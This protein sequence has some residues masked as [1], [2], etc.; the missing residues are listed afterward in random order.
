MMSGIARNLPLILA[1]AVVASTISGVESQ[2]CAR[3]GRKAIACGARNGFAEC[4]PGAK[5]SDDEDEKLCVVDK[6][7]D[8]TADGQEDDLPEVEIAVFPPTP[9]R[10]PVAVPAMK[11]TTE[12]TAATP[13][14]NEPFSSFN[15]I[16]LLRPATG[17]IKESGG[18]H[19]AI[20]G[21]SKRNW[22]MLLAPSAVEVPV[23]SFRLKSSPILLERDPMKFTEMPSS[24]PSSSPS[25]APTISHA[26]SDLPSSS[27]T[28]YIWISEPLPAESDMDN[29]Y[30]DYNPS[31]P[32]GP[33]RWHKVEEQ[34]LEGEYW[35][36]EYSK[37]IEPDLDKNMCDSNSRRQSP[38]DVRLDKVDGQCFEYHEIRHTDG[39]I[40]IDHPKVD[41]QILPTKLR[42]KYPYIV[43]DEDDLKNAPS[44]A[45]TKIET[46]DID[47]SKEE[48][49]KDRVKGPSADVPKGWAYQMPVTHVDIKIPSEHY[50]E[51]V[52]FAM[53]E[54]RQ[55]VEIHIGPTC[56]LS[57]VR[58]SLNHRYHSSYMLTFLLS[59]LHISSLLTETIPRRVSDLSHQRYRWQAWCSR[60]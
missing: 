32:Y 35:E 33:H 42:I 47:G 58:R 6:D 11:N 20:F 21:S 19:S 24:A 4:C 13:G 45:E 5:C 23:D 25:A 2:E 1:A 50:L 28:D 51:G 36:E 37:F 49:L 60:H 10:A 8:P 43:L 27:P 17:G 3:I 29:G 48:V 41:A 54:C 40:G 22:N 53:F 15:G 38:I 16:N 52:S 14:K 34:T 7:Y 44:W 9:A 56:V 59:N 46:D 55:V 26:P 31:S 57:L 12:Q 39:A 18:I 30:F